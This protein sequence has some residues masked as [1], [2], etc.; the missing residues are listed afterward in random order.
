MNEPIK[1]NSF[2]YLVLYPAHIA[3]LA[4]LTVYPYYFGMGTLEVVCLFLGWIFLAGIGSA[5][6]LH[7]YASHKA[8]EARRGLKPV[9]LWLASMCLQGSPLGWASVHRGAHHRFSDGERDPHTPNK[10]RWYSYHGWLWDWGKYYNYKYVVDLIRDPAY[11]FFAQHYQKVV[12]G[13]W[14]LVGLIDWRVLLFLFIVPAVYS[15]HQ[16]SMVNVFCHLKG[17]GY[18]NFETKDQ[19]NNRPVM[20]LLLW[21]Q[22]WHNNHHAKASAYDFGSTVSGKSWE[23]DPTL[24]LLPLIATKESRT[25]IFE[26]RKNAI[27][28][29][30]SKS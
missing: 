5:V 11:L 14:L 4:A 22:A 3:A 30:N 25:K 18:R 15:L 20:G 17:R 28:N 13:T 16:E 24:L 6:T 26:A 12:F 2:L 10:G 9:L 7:R 8:F 23:F 19:S 27:Q 21:G 29:F 1:F